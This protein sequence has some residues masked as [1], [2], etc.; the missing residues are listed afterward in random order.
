M[1]RLTHLGLSSRMA[2]RYLNALEVAMQ[3]LISPGLSCLGLLWETLTTPKG[4][5]RYR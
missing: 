1:I 2:R 5:P 3:P 4:S